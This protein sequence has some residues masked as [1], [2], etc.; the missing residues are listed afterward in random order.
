[1]S[2]PENFVMLTQPSA[3]QTPIFHI[4][5]TPKCFYELQKK[6]KASQLRQRSK[7]D[8]FVEALCFIF[9]WKIWLWKAF[10]FYF[11]RSNI[12]KLNKRFFSS[13]I[14]SI[15]GRLENKKKK[16]FFSDNPGHNIL[17]RFDSPKVKGNLISSAAKL[18]Y[19]FL[20]DSGLTKLQ[21]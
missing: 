10:N 7:F 12:F 16:R 20:N 17:D 15:I 19:E 3:L 5:V 9:T 11:N 8:G 6:Y 2:E 4:F 13:E 14:W 21:N 18:I 1:M